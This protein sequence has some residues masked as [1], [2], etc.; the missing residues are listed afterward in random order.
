MLHVFFPLNFRDFAGSEVRTLPGAFSAREKGGLSAGSWQHLPKQN[1]LQDDL[2]LCAFEA[3][4]KACNHCEGNLMLNVA[5]LDRRS[6]YRVAFR[7]TRVY[8][9]KRLT[10]RADAPLFVGIDP[11][12]STSSAQQSMVSIFFP[13]R[14]INHSMVAT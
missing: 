7:G 9:K 8:L 4:M 12:L 6:P 2:Y 1:S 11:I 13:K 14:L 3:D 10:E 5:G